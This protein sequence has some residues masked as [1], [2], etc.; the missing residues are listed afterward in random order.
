M[1]ILFDMRKI[2]KEKELS[3]NIWA[4]KKDKI[5]PPVK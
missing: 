4:L 5:K 3:N 2:R 1:P